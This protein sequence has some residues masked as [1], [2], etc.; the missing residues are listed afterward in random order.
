MNAS[1]AQSFGRQSENHIMFLAL[2]ADKRGCSCAAYRD[3][4]TYKRW[5]AQGLQVQKGEKSVKLPIYYQQKEKDKE[6]ASEI[7][8]LKT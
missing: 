5:T 3:W 7:L 6:K 4:F 8:E 2:E 1:E